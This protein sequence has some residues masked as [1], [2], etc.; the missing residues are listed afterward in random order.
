MKTKNIWAVSMIHFINNNLGFILYGSIGA[1]VVLS[2]KLVLGNLFCIFVVYLPFLFTKEYNKKEA[3]VS[4][5][6]A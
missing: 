1:D 5:Y 6:S 3:E 2:G 4:N